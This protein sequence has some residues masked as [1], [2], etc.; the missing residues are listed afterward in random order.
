MGI[1][2]LGDVRRM[3]GT[4]HHDPPLP[5]HGA[6]TPRETDLWGAARTRV[7]RHPP[8]DVAASIGG[9][10]YWV[11]AVSCRAVRWSRFPRSPM[12]STLRLAVRSILRLGVTRAMA[13]FLTGTCRDRESCAGGG[14]LR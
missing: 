10:M 13:G 6:G 1:V 11:N 14:G 8:S 12:R 4:R 2:A 9:G 7:R 3:H 5:P